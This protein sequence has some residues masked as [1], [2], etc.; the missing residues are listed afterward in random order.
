MLV[1][2]LSLFTTCLAI[3]GAVFGSAAHAAEPF[4]A[5]VA[6]HCIRCHGPQKEEGDI[7]LDKLSR[8]F[9]AGRDSHHWAAQCSLP[10]P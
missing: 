3:G 10:E 9:K 6:K 2:K 1:R 8:D 5:F 7:R 4:E